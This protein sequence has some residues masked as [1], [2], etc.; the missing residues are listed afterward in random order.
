MVG[1]RPLASAAGA[2]W[3]NRVLALVVRADVGEAAVMTDPRYYTGED[4]REY[5]IDPDEE[6]CPEC[7]IGPLESCAWWCQCL[8]CLTGKAAEKSTGDAA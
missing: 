8:H 6:N 4:E 7:G 1:R 2:L 5:G 3:H